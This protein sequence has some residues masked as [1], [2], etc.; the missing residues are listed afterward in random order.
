MTGEWGLRLLVLCLAITPIRRLSGWRWLAP[1]RRTLGLAAFVYSS[2]HLLTWA[3]LD[4][5]LHG[6]AIVE[7]LSERPF[8]WLGA[9][10]FL[11]LLPL[12]ITS[13]RGWMRRLKRH[14]STLHRLAYVALVLA[15]GHLWWLTK[16]DDRGPI[17][18]AA[19]AALLLATRLVP[20]R[21][22]AQRRESGSAVEA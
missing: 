21:R 8:V 7:D 3:V 14:W 15:V 11:C 22:A 5:G 20:W 10:A 19:V 1:Q 12:A 18:W 16:A 4:Q 6:P 13:T 2:L 17:V 9:S